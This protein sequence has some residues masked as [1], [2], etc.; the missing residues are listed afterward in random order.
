MLTEQHELVQQASVAVDL[1]KLTI[2]Q[3][4]DISKALSGA[5]IVP[6]CATVFL[7]SVISRVKVI[8]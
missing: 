7:S 5:K 1:M 4:M 3:T 8:M 6:H 2:S